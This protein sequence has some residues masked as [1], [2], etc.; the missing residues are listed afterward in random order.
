MIASGDKPTDWPAR[1]RRMVQEQIVR[2][3]VSDPRV[4]AAMTDVPRE[5]FVPPNHI[6]DACDDAPLPIGHGQTISQPFIVAYMTAQ[7]DLQDHHTVLEIGTGSGYQA[8]VLARLCGRVVSIERIDELRATAAARLDELGV[9]NVTVHAGDG[10]T[11]RP[12]DAPFDRIIVTAGAPE[13]PRALRD[14]LAE[15]GVLIAPVGERKEQ[16][17]LRLTKHRERITETAL[18]RCRFVK[19]IGAQGWRCEEG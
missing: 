17:I 7:L 15:D 9:T 5:R 2:R 12:D 13:V 1:R 19:L 16:V 14:Q 11:G 4:L 18:I 10:S 8:A 6:G 3:G